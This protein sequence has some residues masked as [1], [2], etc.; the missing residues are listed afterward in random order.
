MPISAHAYNWGSS[1]HW[2]ILGIFYALIVQ[3]IKIPLSKTESLPPP[4][5]P[6]ISSALKLKLPFYIYCNAKIWLSK[7]LCISHLHLQTLFSS[8]NCSKKRHS[9]FV[10]FKTFFLDF[11]CEITEKGLK[12]TKKVENGPKKVFWPA[13]GVLAAPESWSKYTTN[14]F[15]DLLNF[16]GKWTSCTV[17]ILITFWV[18]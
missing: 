12:W 2:L 1:L 9:F 15:H 18:S 6:S 3:W 11:R 5:S 17:S 4:S 13:L 7:F 16:I 10:H 14:N 8:F